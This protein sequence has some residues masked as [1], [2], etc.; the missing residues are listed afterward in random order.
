MKAIGIILLI[1]GILIGMLIYTLFV[2]GAVLSIL[3]A[4]GRLIKP[5]D[6]V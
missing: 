3:G 4:E 5:E 1:V 6:N 2:I